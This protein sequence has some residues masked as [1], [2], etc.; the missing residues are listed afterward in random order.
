MD[1]FSGMP[2]VQPARHVRRRDGDDERRAVGAGLGGVEALV[3]PRLLPAGF[4]TLR[5]VQRI[6]R[7]GV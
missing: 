6:H 7:R 1:A 5:R 2:D 3:L 4:D